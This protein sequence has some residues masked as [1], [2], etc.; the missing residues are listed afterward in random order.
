MIMRRHR[1]LPDG[2]LLVEMMNRVEKDL[3]GKIHQRRI[4]I[5]EGKPQG[6]LPVITQHLPEKLTA[7]ADMAGEIGPESKQ[8]HRAGVDESSLAPMRGR[9]RCNYVGFVPGERPRSD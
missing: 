5:K 9:N 7:F 4:E 8:L 6:I 1:S 2:T 3:G